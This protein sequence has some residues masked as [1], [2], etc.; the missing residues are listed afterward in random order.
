MNV[1]VRLAD[2]NNW[3]STNRV[4]ELDFY[5]GGAI[6]GIRLSFRQPWYKELSCTV[7]IYARNESDGGGKPPPTPHSE[8]SFVGVLNYTGGFVQKLALEVP[9]HPRNVKQARI[10]VP[11]FCTDAT[12]LEA[13]SLADEIMWDRMTPLGDNFFKV[14]NGSARTSQFAVTVNGPADLECKIPVYIYQ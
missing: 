1:E 11:S 8:G 7:K 12:I 2:S 6:D 10:V 13:K 4:N 3:E 14:N 5:S 9:N